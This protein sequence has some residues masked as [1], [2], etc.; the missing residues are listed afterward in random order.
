MLF[1]VS[2]VSLTTGGSEDT[3]AIDVGRAEGHKCARC[4]RIVDEV[5][6][7]HDTDGL[8]DRCVDAVGVAG[9]MNG[10][11]DVTDRKSLPPVAPPA[12]ERPRGYAR[13][14]EI[15]TILSVLALDQ[16]TKQIVRQMLPLHDTVKIIPGSSTSPTCRTPARPSAC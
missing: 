4:W 7:S 10:P 2:Q 15:V 1:I 9:G 16:M 14:V 11:H 3:L 13:P 8:C 5:S 6:S 12:Q